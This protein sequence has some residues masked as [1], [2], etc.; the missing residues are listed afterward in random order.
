MLLS[1]LQAQQEAHLDKT[2][3]KQSGQV[4]V[5]S[6][7]NPSGYMWMPQGMLDGTNHTYYSNAYNTRGS[8][9]KYTPPPPPG[10]KKATK[11]H[12][13][14]TGHAHKDYRK[15]PYTK[16]G[17]TM[18]LPTRATAPGYNSK[19]SIQQPRYISDEATQNSINNTL[20]Q[21][22]ANADGRF[23]TK[24]L[25]RAGFSRGSGQNFMAAQEGVQ[26]M[27][28]AADSTSEVRASDQRLNDQMRSDYQRAVQQETQNN[29]M[30][31]HSMGQA[32]WQKQFA[33]QSLQAQ[34][35]MA[36]QNAQL[37]LKLALLR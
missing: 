18:Q 17:G 14:P 2:N 11:K 20:A 15:S 23:Q 5:K 13:T 19:S 9:G 31:S 1:T 25:D 21:G 37:Q 27:Q 6:N 3:S 22:Y 16:Q 35:D 28:K 8:Y 10:Q 4:K 36:A 34:L 29:A 30:I 24:N 33:Q 26:Q 32:A 7:F 12:N